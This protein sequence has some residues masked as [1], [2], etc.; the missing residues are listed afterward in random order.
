[1]SDDTQNANDDQAAAPVI[2]VGSSPHLADRAWTTR[3]MMRDVLVALVPALVAA[4]VVFGWLP[5]VKQLA[6]CVV[7]C[8][9]TECAFAA[10]RRQKSPVGDLSAVLTGVILALSLPWNAPFYVPL[11]GAVAAIGLGKAVFGGLGTNIFNPAMVGRAFVMLSF[12][13]VLAAPA[14]VAGKAQL[15]ATEAMTQATPLTVI[16]QEGLGAL[17]GMLGESGSD[18]VLFRFALGNVNG[19]LG[20]VSALALLVGGLYLCVRRSAS[21]EIP[22]GSILGVVVFGGLASMLSLTQLTVPQQL[23]G[24]AFM[25]GAFFIATDPVTTPLTRRGKLV[26]GLGFGS[27]VILI[28]TLSG[29][30]E[31]VMFAILL[32]NAATPLINRWTVPRPVGGPTPEGA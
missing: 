31:G 21:W 23:C 27:L 17:V 8:V 14:Y 10:V 11:L 12:G 9:A 32:M 25:L 26:F 7:F 5:L 18:S 4:A 15:V 20:E 6:I 29:Y 30:P 16:K 28:R 19:S 1:M 3:R 24:G 13:G 2:T 22:A